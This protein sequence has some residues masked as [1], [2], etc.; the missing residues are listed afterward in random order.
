MK[1]VPM[2]KLPVKELFVY[3]T[4]AVKKDPYLAIPLICSIAAIGA[5]ILLFLLYRDSLPSVVPLYYSLPWGEERLAQ[6]DYLL[7]LPAVSGIVV[8]IN[9]GIGLL[10]YKNETV[11]VRMV[12]MGTLLFAVLAVMT[13][14][15]I[16]FLVL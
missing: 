5:G 8:I 2:K 15:R 3:Y 14:Y 12:A 16:I 1:M 6:K 10:V 7:L 4:S 11:L 13:L 9:H